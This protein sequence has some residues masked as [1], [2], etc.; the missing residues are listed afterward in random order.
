MLLVTEQKVHICSWCTFE[1]FTNRML[2]FSTP[3][4]EQT[5]ASESTSETKYANGLDCDPKGNNS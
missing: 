3:L 2:L 4:F 1:I 5:Y